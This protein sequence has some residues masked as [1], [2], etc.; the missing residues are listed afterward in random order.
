MKF[1]RMVMFVVCLLSVF[2]FVYG[3]AANAANVSA[4]GADWEF[5]VSHGSTEQSVNHIYAARV[6]ELLAEKSG[7]HLKMKIFPNSSLAKMRESVEGLVS[8]SIDFF[9]FASAG[10]VEF[11]P[12]CALFDMPCVAPT[13]ETIRVALD[14]ITDDIKPYFENGN[15]KFFGFTDAGFRELSSNRPI[16]KMEDFKGLKVRTMLNKN[17]LMFWKDWG[18]NPTPM[19]YSEVFISLQQ[20]VIDGQENP[21]DLHVDAKFYEVQKYLVFTHHIPFN[22]IMPMSLDTWNS[23]S[24]EYQKIVEESLVQAN[25]DIR[26]YSDQKLAEFEAF[27]TGEGKMEPIHMS[28]ELFNDM[29]SASANT[30]D[31]IRKQVGSELVDKYLAAAQKAIDE[32]KGN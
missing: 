29:K 26:D 27:L 6:A 11:V 12:E 16:H 4:D 30:Y 9:P 19:D 20:G 31:E 7:G 1:E 2:A 23:L 15:M 32:S 22:M 21:L 13:L 25:K 8:G 24:P 3:D 18:A 17:H 5:V 14:A 10:F 28:D